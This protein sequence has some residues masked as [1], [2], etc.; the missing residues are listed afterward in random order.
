MYLHC[1]TKQAANGCKYR[2]PTVGSF[3][4]DC[5]L[6]MF[7]H[8]SKKKKGGIAMHMAVTLEEFDLIL[9]L[10]LTSHIYT[11]MLKRHAALSNALSPVTTPGDDRHTNDAFYLQALA[12][13]IEPLRP[14]AG[15]Q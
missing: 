14:M 9:Q 8:M 5:L 11:E 12:E 6:A 15:A 13:Q 10:R 3:S 7:P 2:I 1:N 4:S